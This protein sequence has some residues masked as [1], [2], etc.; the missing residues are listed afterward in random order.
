MVRR[1]GGTV[2]AFTASARFGASLLNQILVS[3]CVCV[4]VCVCVCLR[5]AGERVFTS[6]S[7][8]P[9]ARWWKTWT[10]LPGTFERVLACLSAMEGGTSSCTKGLE[11]H[12]DWWVRSEGGAPAGDPRTGVSLSPA[13]LHHN[14]RSGDTRYRR[15]TSCTLR[16]MY[17]W[18]C[19]GYFFCLGFC[20]F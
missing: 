20:L 16:A 6:G 7:T 2:L 12:L 14:M 15:P 17:M 4:C 5:P 9:R 10:P 1:F 3:A 11:R 18:Y 13:T 19:K 8:E